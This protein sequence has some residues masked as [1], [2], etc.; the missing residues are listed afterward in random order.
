MSF[1]NIMAVPNAKSEAINFDLDERT[2]CG[3]IIHKRNLHFR[4]PKFGL[5]TIGTVSYLYVLPSHE[6]ASIYRLTRLSPQNVSDTH[7]S[8]A[9]Q[10]RPVSPQ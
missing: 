4:T 2:I 1:G 7:L 9:R 3:P 8:P 10:F 5:Y 6:S